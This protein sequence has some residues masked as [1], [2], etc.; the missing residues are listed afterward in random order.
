MKQRNPKP[1][2]ECKAAEYIILKV[3]Q[4]VDVKHTYRQGEKR[5]RK[6]EHVEDS[7]YR[8]HVLHNR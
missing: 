6:G 4:K 8:A 3:Y 5:K 2:E 1:S 7:A